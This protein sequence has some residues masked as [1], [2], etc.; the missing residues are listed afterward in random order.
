MEREA[1]LMAFSLMPKLSSKMID[2]ETVDLLK[3]LDLMKQD[4]LMKIYLTDENVFNWQYFEMF[5]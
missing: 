5:K 1:A 3:S 2:V 4:I